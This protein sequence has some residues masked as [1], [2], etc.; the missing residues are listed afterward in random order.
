MNKTELGYANELESLKRS[1]EIIDYL[2]EPFGL[3]L[4]SNTFYHPDF[5][6]VYQDRFEIHEVKGFWRDDARVKVKVAQ[7]MFPW[8][9]FKIVRKIKKNFMGKSFVIEEV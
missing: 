2:F 3:R 9:I 4:A 7:E 5:L 6:L 1:G 8:F